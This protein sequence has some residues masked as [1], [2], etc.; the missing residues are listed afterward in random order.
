MA[1]W[2]DVKF[3]AI[4]LSV[5]NRETVMTLPVPPSSFKV[6][7]PQSVEEFEVVSAKDLALIGTAKLK[8]IAFSSFFPVEGHNYAYLQNRSMW[9]WD[10]VYMIDIWIEQKLPI[11]L[12]ISGT[13]INIAVAVDSF[14]YEIKS[15]GDVW[16]SISFKEFN[17][18][19]DAV[20]DN[21]EEE[22]TMSQYEE[23]KASIDNLGAVVNALANPMIYNYIDENMPQWARASVQKLID[24][25]VLAGTGGGWDLNYD[26]LRTI[27]WLDRLGL[28]D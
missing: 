13:P 2:E 3:M 28:I 12:V 10:Y 23:L 22:L 25:G 4:T 5:N 18:L 24:K 11:R 19:E 7:K 21:G 1:N 20:S 14:D 17:L 9:G 16:Y 26:M 6:S 27:V 15:D 8:S